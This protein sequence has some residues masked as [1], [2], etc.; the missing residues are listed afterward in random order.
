[1]DVPVCDAGAA[2]EAPRPI[3]SLV[4][5]NTSDCASCSMPLGVCGTT[6]IERVKR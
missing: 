2:A 6:C 5:P 3:S 1:M 4:I